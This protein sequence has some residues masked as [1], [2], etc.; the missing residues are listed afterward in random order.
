MSNRI[1]WECL[2]RPH[3][4]FFPN[5]WVSVS[6]QSSHNHVK[7]P[8]W[9]WSVFSMG[10]CKLLKPISFR[11][12][13]IIHIRLLLKKNHIRLNRLSVLH[14]GQSNKHCSIEND[15]IGPKFPFLAKSCHLVTYFITN[16][17]WEVHATCGFY[18]NVF[19]R[20]YYMRM[21]VKVEIRMVLVRV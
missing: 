21:E 9:F 12:C 10:H 18:S 17:V 5:R 19:M 13:Q 1:C 7:H 6:I 11:R 3:P 4:V 8:K 20:E 15:F 16:I 2:G 14:K